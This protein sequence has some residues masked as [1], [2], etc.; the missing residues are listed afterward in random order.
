LGEEF[1]RAYV[2]MKMLERHDDASKITACE[3]ET[4]LHA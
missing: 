2:A 3:R 4:T 1:V